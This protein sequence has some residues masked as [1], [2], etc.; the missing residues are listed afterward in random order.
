MISAA[1][2]PC[3]SAIAACSGDSPAEVS[4]ILAPC[5]ISAATSALS[6]TTAAVPRGVKP[7]A[8]TLGSAPA[9]TSSSATAPKLPLSWPRASRDLA[10]SAAELSAER[11][12]SRRIE[13][14]ANQERPASPQQG[15]KPLVVSGVDLRAMLQ[16]QLGDLR[17]PPVGGD[18]QRRVST[19]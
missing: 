5:A 18:H 9:L 7:G 13:R 8:V 16:E 4:S 10:S 12:G 11:P 19:L 1:T 17:I 14:V 15:R 2:S 3:P 6:P